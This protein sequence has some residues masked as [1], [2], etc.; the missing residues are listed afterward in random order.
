MNKQTSIF[1]SQLLIFFLAAWVWTGPANAQVAHP[2]FTWVQ[3]A[4][5]TIQFTNT[6]VGAGTGQQSFFWGFSV[7]NSV[8]PAEQMYGSNGNTPS[9]VYYIPGTYQVTLYRYDSLQG[10]DSVVHPVTVTGTLICGLQST[11][12]SNNASCPTCHDGVAWAYNNL[13]AAPFSFFWSGGGINSTGDS[14]KNLGP[15]QYICTVTDSL[16][17]RTMDTTVIAAAA[18]CIVSF[19]STVSQNWANVNSNCSGLTSA[20]QA[21]WSVSI[22]NQ[23]YA[24]VL[25]GYTPA[26]RYFVCLIVTD[27]MNMGGCTGQYCDSVIVPGNPH[28]QAAFSLAPDPLHAGNYIASDNSYDGGSPVAHYIWSW[29]DSTQ[30]DTIAMPTHTYA[31]AG[32]YQMCLSIYTYQGCTSSTCNYVTTHSMVSTAGTH[33]TINVVKGSPAMGILEENKVLN[34]WNLYPN[35]GNEAMHLEYNLSKSS[36]VDIRI[37]NLLGQEVLKVENNTEQ[38][39]GSHRVDA[40]VGG[41]DVGTYLVQI[42]TDGHRETKRL[43]VIR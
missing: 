32:T 16:G 14:A 40:Q 34:S 26:G 4:P 7:H 25:G 42:V 17:C 36:V 18:P 41:L 12:Y 43:T 6:T 29:G 5:N 20:S 22:G 19:T 24:G 2:D 30:A 33:T 27:S 11:A 15:G 8:Y 28:C 21:N 38:Q 9:H 3:T 39:A 31:G 13:G 10:I 37:Y 35:P 1:R 23:P